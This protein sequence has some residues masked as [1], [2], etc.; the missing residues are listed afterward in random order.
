[1]KDAL[2][3]SAIL[4]SLNI[5]LIADLSLERNSGN[6]GFQRII[7]RTIIKIELFSFSI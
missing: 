5:S 3:G 7:K 2:L 1:M 6:S 4:S